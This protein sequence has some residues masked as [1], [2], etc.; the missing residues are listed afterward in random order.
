[1]LMWRSCYWGY[2]LLTEQQRLSG[3][4]K[5]V[6]EGFLHL[7]TSGREA[8]QVK[9]KFGL[10]KATETYSTEGESTRVSTCAQEKRRAELENESE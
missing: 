2:R 6:F 8:K 5:A 4:I 9:R 1:M 7:V 10:A 3:A